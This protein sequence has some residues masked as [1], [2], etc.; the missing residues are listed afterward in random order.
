[1]NQKK[2]KRGVHPF[3]GK[4]FSRDMAVVS[5][6]ADSEMVYPLSQHIGAPAKAVVS[7]GDRVLRGQ[8]LAEADG[9]ISAPVYSA[10]SGTVKAVEPRTVV[11]G[12]KDVCIVVEN[13]NADERVPDFGKECSLADLTADDIVCR[14]KSAGVVGLGGA[15]FPTGVKL[16][17]KN[18]QNVDTLIINGSEC[19]PYLTADYRLMIEKGQQLAEGIKAVLKVLDGAKAVIALE[20]NKP[21]AVSLLEE[22]TGSEERISVAVLDTRY[23]QGGE[24]QLIYSITGRKINSNMLPADVGCLVLN[25]ATCYAIYEAVYKNMPLLH[26]VITVTGEGVNS[27]CNLDVPLGI[28][29]SK[30]LEEAGGFKEDA[31]KFICGGPMMGTAMGTLEVPVVKTSYSILVFCQDDVS[32]LPQS[33]CIHCGRCVGVCPEELV[34]QLL[35]KAVKAE[36]FERFEALDGMECMECG[37][38]TY[39]CPAKIPLTQMFKLGKSEVREMRIVD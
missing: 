36:D 18:P 13:D 22:I 28:S 29:F 17:P 6:S 33:N 21:E 25:V 39:I 10:V 16:L 30:V 24:R 31:V 37:C 20:N 1:M 8:M 27:P 23:P 11:G 35:S 32:V 5:V 19:E 14:I 2:L 9:T 26:R 15:G 12:R 3:E 4:E 34:P 38:C 7:V